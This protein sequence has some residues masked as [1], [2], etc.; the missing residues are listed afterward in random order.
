MSRSG[1]SD[2]LDPRELAQHVSKPRP[3]P[4]S[5]AEL[6]A[7]MNEQLLQDRLIYGTSY[8]EEHADGSRERIDPTAVVLHEL[9]RDRLEPDPMPAAIERVSASRGLRGVLR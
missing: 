9:G 8:E 2:G 6:R 3:P 5:A 7:R 1:Y 4:T